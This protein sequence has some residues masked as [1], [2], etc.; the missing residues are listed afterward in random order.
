MEQYPLAH[1]ITCSI[2]RP[3]QLPRN[4]GRGQHTAEMSKPDL[5]DG[6]SRAK[7]LLIGDFEASVLCKV[8]G[9]LNVAV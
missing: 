5:H 9:A 2:T 7:H 3:F 6:R 4:S 8:S 1:H